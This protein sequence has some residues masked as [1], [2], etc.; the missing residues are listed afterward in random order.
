MRNR[1]S[2]WMIVAAVTLLCPCAVQADYMAVGWIVSNAV[3]SDATLANALAQAGNPNR[4]DFTVS[5]LNFDSRVGAGA[6]TIGGFIN[7]LGA[8]TGVATY[9]GIATAATLLNSA[10]GGMLFEFTGTASFTTGQSFTLAH[11]DGVQF[12]VG[13]TDAACTPA[14]LVFNDP[15]PT[16]PVTNTFTYTGPSGNLPFTF[17][18]GECCGDPAVFR[19]NLVP[20]SE[21]PEPGSI[22]LLS[23]VLAGVAFGLRRKIAS[24]Y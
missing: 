20:V 17:T 24:R 1:R 2:L 5:S 9:G 15:D 18:Y 22:V 8:Q 10:S 19:T 3:A 16:P 4:V 23:T 7:S 12:Y 6:N 11:D 13:C 21:I 14:N